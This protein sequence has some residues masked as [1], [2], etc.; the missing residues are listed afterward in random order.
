MYIRLKGLPG[1]H[2]VTP[3]G[4][5]LRRYGLPTPEARTRKMDAFE[6]YCLQQPTKLPSLGDLNPTDPLDSCLQLY[7]MKVKSSGPS[8]FLFSQLLDICREQRRN[9]FDALDAVWS[10]ILRLHFNPDVVLL[11]SILTA[12]REIDHPR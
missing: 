11:T 4:L 3:L 1:T 6:R 8:N 5:Q 10:D 2:C 7:K 9:L 12:S